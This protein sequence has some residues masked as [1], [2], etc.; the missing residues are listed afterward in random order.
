[1]RVEEL[2]IGNYVKFDGVVEITCISND[3]DCYY[4]P[5]DQ[6]EYLDEFTDIRHFEPIPLTPEVLEA[7]GFK[8][9]DNIEDW[10]YEND[11]I[12]IS[13]F[14]DYFYLDLLDQQG[15]DLEIR[16]AHQLQNLYYAITGKELTIDIDKLKKALK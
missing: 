14:D 3:G 8:Y 12:R 10:G 11:G 4:A 9:F 7:C 16:S 6:G 5:V 13:D 15:I 1:M 2:R